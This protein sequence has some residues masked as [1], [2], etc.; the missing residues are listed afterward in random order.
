[1]YDCL[2]YPLECNTTRMQHIGDLNTP[3]TGHFIPF[4]ALG[5]LIVKFKISQ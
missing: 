2:V 4:D 1:M 3:P 5:A